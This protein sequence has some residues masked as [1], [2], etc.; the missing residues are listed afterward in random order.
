MRARGG[1]V[2][3]GRRCSSDAV[4]LLD[5]FVQL[6][7]RGDK[8]L[9]EALDLNLVLL[10]LEQFELRVVVE[11]VVQ[12]SAVDLVHADGDFEISVLLGMVIIALFEQV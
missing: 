12:L 3:F 5:E 7:F 1:V 4:A 6:L 11:Q 2:G 10:V 8:L 9:L